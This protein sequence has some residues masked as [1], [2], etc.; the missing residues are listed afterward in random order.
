MV[1][2]DRSAYIYDW[3]GRPRDTCVGAYVCLW[4]LL[5]RSCPSVFLNMPDLNMQFVRHASEVVFVGCTREMLRTNM[6]SDSDMV[7]CLDVA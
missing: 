7:N 5:S 6:R 3:Q 4:R 1:V 2:D